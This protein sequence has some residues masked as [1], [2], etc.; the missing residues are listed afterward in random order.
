MKKD[1]TRS[2]VWVII[3]LLTIILIVKVLQII[4]Q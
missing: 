2:I 3:G 1:Y 4:T